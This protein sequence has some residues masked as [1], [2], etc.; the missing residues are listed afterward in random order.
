MRFG[1]NSRCRA[2][3]ANC[4]PSDSAAIYV[5]RNPY[6]I[7][8]MKR[9]VSLFVVLFQSCFLLIGGRLLAQDRQERA[10]PVEINQFF[11][12]VS[13]G[14]FKPLEQ[15]L[16]VVPRSKN[17]LAVEGNR[18]PIRFVQGEP[19]SFVIRL[20]SE[21]ADPA[22]AVQFLKLKPQ[23]DYR[24]LERVTGASKTMSYAGLVPFEAESYEES[25]FKIKPKSG[26][27]AG[28]YALTVVGEKDAY[29]FGVDA[30]SKEL[31]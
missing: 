24:V 30:P 13:A 21:I 22:S 27:S 8:T 11:F 5:V 6:I 12:F 31:K 25:S 19:L 26:L 17:F 10:E 23:G 4:V 28:E 15:Q 14:Q 20:A 9:P 29:C 7:V 18:S 16:P 2:T 3:S 1:C